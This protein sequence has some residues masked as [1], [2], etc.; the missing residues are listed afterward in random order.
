M[1]LNMLAS[2]PT[3]WRRSVARTLTTVVHPMFCM[4]LNALTWYPVHPMFCMALNIGLASCAPYVV[5]G[6]KSI[7][8]VS[9]V[10]CPG[11]PHTCPES[12]P[13]QHT[14]NQGHSG[15]RAVR[16]RE[17]RRRRGTAACGHGCYAPGPWDYAPP[18]TSRGKL[19]GTCV[20][21]G[22]RTHTP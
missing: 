18:D 14:G 15:H 1:G 22:V 7:D 6:V 3:Q 8:L 17:I 10:P 12:G 13:P 11:H 2:F 9:L 4:V 21:C 16:S 5:Y 20:R 19:W